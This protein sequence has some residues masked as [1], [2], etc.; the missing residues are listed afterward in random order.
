MHEIPGYF[1]IP[2]V[3][4]DINPINVDL[5]IKLLKSECCIVDLANMAA[6][7]LTDCLL[8]SNLKRVDHLK[9]S[10]SVEGHGDTIEESS[11]HKGGGVS[12]GINIFL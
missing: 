12:V 2:F 11:I 8:L 10:A 6:V 1:N 7:S 5:L 9:A 3:I 4:L